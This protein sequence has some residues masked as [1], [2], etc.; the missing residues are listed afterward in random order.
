MDK[1]KLIKDF[2]VYLRLERGLSEN[3]L[4]N[5]QLDIEKFLNFLAV[6]I[7]SIDQVGEEEVRAFIY[8]IG[9]FYS[10]ATQA[11]FLASLNSFFTY[12]QL[13]ERIRHNPV[14]FIE[15]PKMERKLP[16][17][18]TLDEIY[19]IIDTIP[20]TTLE[21][22][23]NKVMLETLYSCGFRVSELISLKIS[24]LFF[25]EGFVRVIGKGNKQRLVPIAPH[26][27]EAI[28]YYLSELRGK[29]VNQLFSTDVLFLNRRGKPLTRA[30]IFILVKK[31][32]QLAGITKE[33]S[34][35]TFRHSFA[36]HLLE[37]GANLFA[38]QAMLGHESITTTE[39]YTHIEQS[40][41]K[42]VIENF[43][44]WNIKN[45]E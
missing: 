20:D 10:T 1:E 42:N 39:I 8:S 44:P 27:Q 37:N 18:L 25:D 45:Q 13:E 29:M 7:Q 6:E 11:R 19:K 22:Q 5:Y 40:A 14:K 21:E 30:M 9:N 26:T 23:R 17:V 41:L 15:H 31:Y 2:S 12:L 28:F 33:V 16:V 24:D 32:A 38:I 4:I 35:H 43:H 3:T 36:T 34:P